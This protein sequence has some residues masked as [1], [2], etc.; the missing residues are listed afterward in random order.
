M[1]KSCIRET[2]RERLSGMRYDPDEVPQLSTSL[3]ESIKARVKG[4]SSKRDFS[5]T[6]L[7]E[8]QRSIWNI[9]A[10]S[11]TG[12]V[13]SST[14]LGFDRYK[15]VVHVVIGEQRGQGVKWD[16]LWRQSQQWSE[17]G[18]QPL[19]HSAL[20]VF[21]QDVFEVLMGCRHWQLCG[22]CFH[23]CRSA[24]QALACTRGRQSTIFLLSFICLPQDSL[25][26]AVTVFG[27]YYYWGWKEGWRKSLQVF[28]PSKAAASRRQFMTAMNY[29]SPCLISCRD[30]IEICP[31][32]ISSCFY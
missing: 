13:C 8:F 25:F 28:V 31:G 23:E 4:V 16:I 9:R 17:A 10:D 26:C 22:G 19:W 11:L 27:S 29:S 3:A 15:L 2:V 21:T 1:V 24:L 5:E 12:E 20:F 6:K 30:E 7:G 14:A 18:S 32:H